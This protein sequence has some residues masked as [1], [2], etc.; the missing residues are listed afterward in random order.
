MVTVNGKI[1]RRASLNKELDVNHLNIPAKGRSLK[2]AAVSDDQS[3]MKSEVSTSKVAPQLTSPRG[4]STEN[5]LN[6]IN[7]IH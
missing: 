7:V 1:A 3:A 2:T 6:V 5:Q 4:Y